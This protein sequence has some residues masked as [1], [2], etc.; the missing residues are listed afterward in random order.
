M[1]YARSLRQCRSVPQAERPRQ[2]TV[3]GN[4]CTCE[5]WDKDGRYGVVLNGKTVLA[6]NVGSHHQCMSR[7][8]SMRQCQ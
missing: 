2:P 6:P 7:A 1:D 5:D 8:Q 4:S 3:S